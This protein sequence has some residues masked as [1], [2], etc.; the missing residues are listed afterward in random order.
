MKLPIVS[1][2]GSLALG[3][4][5]VLAS[6]S[7]SQQAESTT[8]PADRNSSLGAQTNVTTPAGQVQTKGGITLTPYDDSPKFPTA[9][10]QLNSPVSGSTMPSGPVTFSYSLTNFQLT[11]M[12][13]SDHAM[14][15]ANSMKGQH[16]H[17]IVDDQPYTAH[18][19][20]K[21]AEPV[22]DG[23]HVILSFLSR[24]YHESIKHQGAY[25]LRTITVGTPAAGTAPMA[26]DTKAPTLFYSRPKDTYS[27]KD[28]QK[29]MLDFYLVNTTLAPDGNKVRATINGTEFMLDQWIPYMMEGLPAGQATIKLELLDSSG[30]LIPGPYNSVTR[31]ITVAP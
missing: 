15:M 17:L 10:M 25:D 4:L 7:T 19:D 9:Q 23:Q 3:A 18:Y 13:A 5:A 26:F 11:N 29:I 12:T 30:T 21:F 27:G 20:T 22:A 1:L 14:Q 16:I 31:T 8:A 2:T 24:S 28:A 6:C